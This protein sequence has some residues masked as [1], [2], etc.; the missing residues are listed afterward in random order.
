MSSYDSF[1][2][3]I[4]EGTADIALAEKGRSRSA[5]G[6]AQF[7]NFYRF[8][9]LD[10]VFDPQSIDDDK[11]AHWEHGLGV[12]N[13]ELA[14]ALPRNAII[15]QRV[16]EGT[17]S[18]A[19]Q[20]MFLFP[21]LPPALS[22]PCNPG[23][24]VWAFFE[25]K[26]VKRADLGYW[27][28]RIVGPGFVED[29]NHTHMP[30]AYDASFSPG[31]KG[32]HDGT[33]RAQH[34]FRA[35]AAIELSDGTRETAQET[36]TLRST[37]ERAYERLM[38]ESDAGR[39]RTYEPVPRYRKRP[40]D[41]AIEGSNNALIVIG[42]HRLGPVASYDALGDDGSIPSRPDGDIDGPS[43]GA[44]DMVVGRGQVPETLGDVVVNSIGAN[45][46]DKSST[47]A[48]TS[49]G[50]PDLS[51]DRSRVMLT[52]RS[53]V[54]ADLE[55]D[56]FNGEF[57]IEDRNGGDAAVVVKSDKV[58]I[59]ARS[60]VELLVQGFDRDGEGKMVASFDESRWAAI[61]IRSNGDVI[62][63]PASQ[64][65]LKLGGDDADKALLCTDQPAVVVAGQ[66]SA[67]PI[68][69][70][71]GGLVGTNAGGQG[72]FSTKILVR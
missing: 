5:Q 49:E 61:V 14:R 26:S 36:S 38:L 47:G 9:V 41:V 43:S 50:D 33:A 57:S 70:T 30:R 48:R 58:R 28:C 11:I 68:A 31:A 72:T 18:E 67:P 52:Q 32:L 71:M 66:V 63:R 46:V 2:R 42:Q 24:H 15:A 19:E 23:E 16:L 55:I 22:L 54:D 60:D 39:L 21:M 27:L 7:S 1:D 20:P 56:G 25:N 40:A 65:V 37:D 69:S 29:A 17:A 45:E 59:V 62:L 44:I 51:S 10:A 35:G 8:I 3:Q 34:E 12:R 64:G 4:A 13:V 53:R 6:T